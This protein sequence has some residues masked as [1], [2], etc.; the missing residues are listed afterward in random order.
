MSELYFLTLVQYYNAVSI[1]IEKKMIV[2][3]VEGHVLS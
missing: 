1:P 3:I 2:V